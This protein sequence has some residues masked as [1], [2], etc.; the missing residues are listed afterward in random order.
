MDKFAVLISVMIAI[1]VGVSIVPMIVSAVNSTS[2]ITSTTSS[3]FNILIYVFIAVI[4]MGAVTWMSGTSTSSN[5]IERN[6]KE[7]TEFLNKDNLGKI[8]AQNISAIKVEKVEDSTE[9]KEI[10]EPR[11]LT[12]KEKEGLFL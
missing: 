4:V 6:I 7:S 3:L 2:G 10:E 12:Q 5:R 1:G 11:K 9:V 8:R